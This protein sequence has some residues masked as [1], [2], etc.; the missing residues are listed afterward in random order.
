[1]LDRVTKNSRTMNTALAPR[2]HPPLAAAKGIALHRQL[3]LVL[4]DQISRSVFA[5]GSALPNE[6]TMC[7]RFHVSRITVRRALA[8]LVTLGLIE[9]RHG[10]GTFVR[11]DLPLARPVPSLGLIDSLRKTAESTQ[12]EVLDVAR[13]VPPPDIAALLQL[14][15]DELAVNALRLRSMGR[16][17][18]ML[19]DAWVP[20][21]LGK[22]ITAAALKRQAL[23]EI[24]L[25]Q[26]IRFGRAVQEITAVAADASQARLLQ[27]ELGS[28]LL[29]LVR[30]IHD[31]ESVPVQHLTAYLAPAHSRI[32]MEIPGETVNSLSAGR[33]VFDAT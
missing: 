26:G 23:Y 19:T 8:D 20:A 32:L 11:L 3:F 16:S 6:E 22:R 10:L 13:G 9:K 31:T 25:S 28:P 29:K 15:P 2:A 21:R 17:P 33:M 27:T 12:A 24:L 4:R 14:A 30:V 5:P 18:V 1:M 7:E